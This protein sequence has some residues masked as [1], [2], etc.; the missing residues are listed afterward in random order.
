[1]VSTTGNHGHADINLFIDALA[2]R[3][4]GWR[5]IRKGTRQNVEQEENKG[6]EDK[7]TKGDIRNRK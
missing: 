2:R 5:R 7:E 6:A 1:M 4:V 3:M